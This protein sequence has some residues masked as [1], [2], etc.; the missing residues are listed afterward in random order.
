MANITGFV[1]SAASLGLSAIMVKPKRGFYAAPGT[2][3]QFEPFIAQ[4]TLEEVHNDELEITDHPVEQGAA[5]TD[6]AF[7]RPAE[8]VIR[9]GWSNSPQQKNSLTRQGISVAATVLGPAARIVAGTVAS[10]NAAQSLL[11]GKDPQS[12]INA[13][14]A[15]LLELQV[16]RVPFDVYTG[17]R[18]YRNMLFKGLTVRTDRKTEN[19]LEVVA[20]CREI[21][22][23]N[24]TVVSVPIN[25][26][27]QVEP[28]K[29]NPTQDEGRKQLSTSPVEVRPYPRTET[30]VEEVIN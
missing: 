3:P 15:R 17:K 23:V 11:L 26:Q 5:I 9:C 16:S 14:Y 4:A 13:L 10:V 19:V 18:V 1:T 7:K 8:V 28:E 25:K 27:A 12:Q 29:T 6:H 22:I 30:I 2:T 21:I 20:R 24:T